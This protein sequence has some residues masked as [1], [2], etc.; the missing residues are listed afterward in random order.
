MVN[1]ILIYSMRVAIFLSLS[2]LGVGCLQNASEP[3]L[4]ATSTPPPVV[5]I[6]G[7]PIP[8]ST[9]APTP[10][11]T[12]TAVPTMESVVLEG[13][14]YRDDFTKKDSGWNQIA[15]DNSYIGYHEPGYYHVE[16]H[17]PYSDELVPV[18]GQSFTD[19]TVELEVFA[20]ADLSVA[21]GDYYYG[22]AFRRSGNLFYA[23]TISPNTKGWVV[24][25]HSLAGTEILRE[26]SEDA[27]QGVG[28]ADILRVDARGEDFIFHINGEMVAQARDGDYASGEV[29]FYVQSLDNTKTHI[30]FDTITILDVDIAQEGLLYRDDFTKK[31]S[32]WNQIAFDNSYIG[33]HE[34]GYY[35]VEVHAP[36][37]DELVPVPGQSF[38]DFTVE[39]EVF[40]D[41]DLSVAEGDYYYGLAFRRSG[42]LFYAFT[43]SPN[44]KG[45]VVSK[46]S[47]AGTEILRE[48][49]EDAIQGVGVADILRVDVRGEDFIFHINGEMVAQARDGDYASGEVGF[50]VQSLDNTKTH[51]HFDNITIRNVEA[52]QF[53]CSVVVQ[54]VNLRSGPGKDFR[55]LITLLLGDQFEPLGRT[56]DGLWIQA[57]LRESNLEGWVANDRDYAICNLTIQDLP[58][59]EP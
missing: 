10:S 14:L 8:T 55:R 35:H 13:L 44:T 3:P 7:T 12:E 5:T 9:V 30:H 47:L 6:T 28:V 34:P 58:A 40:A 56:Q 57:R 31:D 21:E 37:S 33:Y 50:Y 17:A 41:A 36:Y 15:F 39:L 27:I 2:I 51:I 29:G 24:S 20:D 53:L 16:V 26:G 25:K 1:S 48:G 38:T 45:W 46:H 11:A 19:F 49:S 22:L 32:G 23:F 43:I 59:S 52:P 18:P 42:N 4:P 54:S